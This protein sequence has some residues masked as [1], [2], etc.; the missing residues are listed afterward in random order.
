VAAAS[1]GRLVE[2]L[3]AGASEEFAALLIEEARQRLEEETP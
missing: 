1:P 2:L 3:G